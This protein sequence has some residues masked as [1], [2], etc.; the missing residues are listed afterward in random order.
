VAYYFLQWMCRLEEFWANLEK[1]EERSDPLSPHQLVRQANHWL[2]TRRYDRAIERATMALEL[3][4][5]SPAARSVLQE[6]YR[7]L[8]EHK[9]AFELSLIGTPEE[10]VTALTEI[11]QETGLPGVRRRNF[12]RRKDKA[13][14]STL[15]AMY[16]EFGEYDKAFERLEKHW[17]RPLYGNHDSPACFWWD[18]LRA[19]PRFK[20]LLRKLNLPEEAIQRHL[21]LPTN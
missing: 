18:P 20:Q 5:E 8:G 12:D 15:A 19:D 13:R 10:E 7:E 11:F 2:W 6:A 14:D 4:P 1:L 21:A 3:E 9:K 17:E 16:A